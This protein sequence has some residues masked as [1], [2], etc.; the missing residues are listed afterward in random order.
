MWRVVGYKPRKRIWNCNEEGFASEA[1]VLYFTDIWGMAIN[2][3]TFFFSYPSYYLKGETIFL[4][5]ILT[6][7]A[8]LIENEILI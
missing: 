8:S 3:K 2:I 5:K 4:G 1:F 6:I 7:C